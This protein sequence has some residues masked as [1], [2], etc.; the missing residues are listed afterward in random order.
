MRISKTRHLKV[1]L[2]N[3]ESADF[4][5]TVTIEHGD[6]GLTDEEVQTLVR[7]DESELDALVK[8]MNEKCE[9]YIDV[10]L[11]DD[12]QSCR[13]ITEEDR[14]ILIRAFTSQRSDTSTS[15]EQSAPTRRPRRPRA[16]SK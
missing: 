15:R 12:I 7:G 1:N 4:G 5:G 11:V 10:L 6:L 14:S 8:R 3:Y 9:Q 16:S 2:G 13:D